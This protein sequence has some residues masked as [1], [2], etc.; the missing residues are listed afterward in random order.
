[1]SCRGSQQGLK[2]GQTLTYSVSSIAASLQQVN[3]YL[4]AYSILRGDSAE[5]A[6]LVMSLE[7]K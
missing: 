3:T 1:M 6:M 2:K 5:S 7:V 4:A